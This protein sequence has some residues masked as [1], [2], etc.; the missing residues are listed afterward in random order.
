MIESE[1]LS[2]LAGI[3][4]GEGTITV[5]Y[6]KRKSRSKYG[7]ND[8][9]YLTPRLVIANTSEILMSESRRILEQICC[10]SVSRS[11][12]SRRTKLN[13]KPCY[14]FA[15]S[16]KTN[17]KMVLEKINPYLRVKRKQGELLLDFC[18]LP[19]RGHGDGHG[20]GIYPERAYEIAKEVRKLNGGK[21][22]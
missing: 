10:V 19:G 6:W 12:H 15:I 9:L 5:T 4:D 21:W 16:G 14:Q 1:E 8:I 2:Y 3:I 7:G 17:I 18:N 11:D 22:N 13:H 20:I